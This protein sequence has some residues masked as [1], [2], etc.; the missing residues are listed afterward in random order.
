MDPLEAGKAVSEMHRKRG[1]P[2]EGTPEAQPRSV[3]Q[4]LLEEITPEMIPS[5]ERQHASETLGILSPEES[6]VS[7]RIQ[8]RKPQDIESSKRHSFDTRPDVVTSWK[9][10]SMI[11]ANSR[12]SIFT[13]VDPASVR[14][15]LPAQVASSW[16][17]MVLGKD[18]RLTFSVIDPKKPIYISAKDSSRGYRIDRGVSSGGYGSIYFATSTKGSPVALKFIKVHKNLLIRVDSE[19]GSGSANII[20]PGTVAG[21][22]T[23]YVL[24]RSYG[25]CMPMTVCLYD[26]FLFARPST[27]DPKSPVEWYIVMAMEKMKGDVMRMVWESYTHDI[28]ADVKFVKCIKLFTKMTRAIFDLEVQ[29]IFHNDI[30]PQNFLYNDDGT[31]KV[32]DFDLGCFAS[33]MRGVGENSAL[34]LRQFINYNTDGAVDTSKDP[35]AHNK[36]TIAFMKCI[37]KTTINYEPPE[38]K[39]MRDMWDLAESVNDKQKVREIDVSTLNNPDWLSRMMA[40][41]LICSFR[42]LI[43]F[44]GLN[45]PY[46]NATSPGFYPIDVGNPGGVARPKVKA[47]DYIKMDFDGDFSIAPT[48]GNKISLYKT[49]R[50]NSVV[51]Q[52]IR[53][54]NVRN[55]VKE[56]NEKLA[57]V[58]APKIPDRADPSTELRVNPKTFL[59]VGDM[60]PD[61]VRPTIPMLMKFMTNLSERL[62]IV[63]PDITRDA[64]I[65]VPGDISAEMNI[66]QYMVAH[67]K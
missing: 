42:E 29:S 30:K 12:S 36:Q 47:S 2:A 15:E 45:S 66:S 4:R 63:A 28:S 21:L 32:T 19:D 49:I 26:T 27:A 54:E 62:H 16:S 34:L 5:I 50:L 56:F 58:I 39:Y 3:S 20:S 1:R 14:T 55:V 48:T 31:V 11:K 60:N 23:H 8:T 22:F 43:L 35:W 65:S 52:N 64:N 6:S 9:V 7:L 41:Q 46:Y 40:Y 24:Q 10:R 51:L 38:Y 17:P 44:A 53:D 57:T 13:M 61:T 25:G 33:R 59:S 18:G 67:N 37:F